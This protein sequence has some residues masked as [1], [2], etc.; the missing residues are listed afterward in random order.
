M[1]SFQI[2]IHY[3]NIQRIL[4]RYDNIHSD[5]TL[6]ILN[7]FAEELT[8]EENDQFTLTFS[9]PGYIQ[10][11]GSWVRNH[12]LQLLQIGTKLRLRID[13]SRVID[14]IIKSATPALNKENIIYNFTA[15]DELSYLWSKHNLGY[16]YS[17]EERGGVETI[18]TIVKNVLQD[19]GLALRWS[20]VDEETLSNY[21]NIISG[22]YV[23]VNALGQKPMS[24]EVTNSNP[25]NV[26]IEACNTIGCYLSVNYERGELSFFQKNQIPF[27]GFRYRPESNL[28]ELSVDFD[29]SELSTIL[30]VSGGTNEYG[31]IISMVPPIPAGI[32]EL[33][34]NKEDE[35]NE[36]LWNKIQ[37][38]G[39]Y[40]NTYQL[41]YGGIS[42][43]CVLADADEISRYI[44]HYLNEPQQ[45]TI[46]VEEPPKG[47]TTGYFSSAFVFDFS[48]ERE[49]KQLLKL[50]SS[51]DAKIRMI[52]GWLN[53][54]GST[55]TFDFNRENTQVIARFLELLS[56][57]AQNDTE[58]MTLNKMRNAIESELRQLVPES[59]WDTFDTYK[60][61]NKFIILLE[62]ECPT[63]V[64]ELY[65]YDQ[66]QQNSISYSAWE[67]QIN[68]VILIHNAHPLEAADK[69]VVDFLAIARKI[70][71]LGQYFY[72]FSFFEK[73]G[74]MSATQYND[75]KTRINDMT[76]NN[77]KLRLY[78]PSY[79]YI[80]YNILSLLTTLQ[81][82]A[83]Q[84]QAI[85]KAWDAA[86]QGRV[87][88]DAVVSDTEYITKLSNILSEMHSEVKAVNN[89]N[90]DL[91]T[92]YG[93]VQYSDLPF[94]KEWAELEQF[95]TDK[96]K[97]SQDRLEE[98]KA[99][100]SQYPD[101]ATDINPVRIS[102]ESEEA[103][104]EQQISIYKTFTAS[105]N[106]VKDDEL[107]YEVAGLYTLMNNVLQQ[108]YT[109]TQTNNRALKDIIDALERDN[110]LRWLTIYQDYGQF[111]YEAQYENT[112]ELDSIAL[113][114]QAVVYFEEQKLP[115]ANYSISVLDL[116]VLEAIGMPR[117]RTGSKIAVY[118]EKLNLLDNQEANIGYGNNELVVT[119]LSYNLRNAAKVSVTVEQVD[120][121]QSI[122]AKLLKQAK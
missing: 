21:Y 4:T 10:Q 55:T 12:W 104:L 44:D 5:P 116:G 97:E 25:Y 17:T 89:L 122:L 31:E 51:E 102:L 103:Q 65:L 88:G 92:I 86:I 74:L 71:H 85:A 69:E 84:Y 120:T 37:V 121:Y 28:S 9:V 30:H 115:N 19:N 42:Q 47:G 117:L 83:E 8:E 87:E 73:N 48:E 60:N 52:I 64:L 16:S 29:G 62:V 80:Q 78:Y 91:Y 35:W 67:E 40:S 99:K 70:P 76:A 61:A 39:Q 46:A 90:K 26:I 81:V 3:R 59:S 11:N 13:G 36:D 107:L 75:L 93:Y 33:I 43:P 114:N 53:E 96:L 45:T 94:V 110:H 27:S 32:Q 41:K 106:I 58:F 105:W 49:L 38:R 63:A 15:Q 112:D 72:D 108:Y 34:K 101:D 109:P 119:A 20:V 118:N 66:L 50:E 2:E 77:I 111:I 100:L 22:E 23:E 79:Y 54:N 6:Q 18:Y 113:Y 82:K 68:N 95:Y 56:A 14:L 98:V 7:T 24:L 57:R 1:R